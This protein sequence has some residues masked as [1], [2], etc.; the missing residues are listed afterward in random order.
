MSS[1]TNN[2][3]SEYCL[4]RNQQ[5][6]KNGKLLFTG[7]AN[8]PVQFLTEAYKHFE[9]N[10]PKFYKMDNLCKLGLI[11][12]EILLLNK[13]L[14]YKGE[15]IGIV[16]YNAASSVD[17]D[18]LHQQSINDR[19]AY[20]PSPSVFVYTLPNIVIGEICIRKKISGE[21]AFFISKSFDPDALNDYVEDLFSEGVIQCCIAG[22]L[23]LD[24]DYYDGVLFLVEKTISDTDRIAIFEAGNIKEIYSQST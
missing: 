18:R 14:P 1:S 11:A 17:T 20:F 10:Y 3:I 9:I 21:S 13:S 5:I 24:G 7:S 6:N 22:W 16:L 19:A 2:Y 23:E 8:N 12:S 4:I 15:E